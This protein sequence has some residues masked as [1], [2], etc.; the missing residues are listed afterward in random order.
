ME[1]GAKRPIRSL[2]WLT[3]RSTS[4]TWPE[5]HLKRMDTE[6]AQ[7]MHLLEMKITKIAPLPSRSRPICT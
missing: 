4:R 2:G 3:Q 7:E 5:R 6:N 1:G